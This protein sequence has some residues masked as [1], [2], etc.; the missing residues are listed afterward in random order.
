MICRPDETAYIAGPL[1]WIKSLFRSGFPIGTFRAH[2][3]DRGK[4]SSAELLE[5]STRI[6]HCRESMGLCF[7][8]LSQNVV[9]FSLQF[10]K[11][12]LIDCSHCVNEPIRPVTK[13][14]RGIHFFKN[15][16]WGACFVEKRN[17]IFPNC[18][19]A[20]PDRTDRG[21]SQREETAFF[22]SIP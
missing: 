18:S 22:D 7:F 9:F 4:D 19:F 20:N 8:L 10:L 1:P 12:R 11:N 5:R 14:T 17:R 6:A 2:V 15:G 13:R 16:E 21:T 3:N